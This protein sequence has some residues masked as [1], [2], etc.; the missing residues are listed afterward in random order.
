MSDLW[1]WLNY[2]HYCLYCQAKT[3]VQTSQNKTLNQS[4]LLT[5]IHKRYQISATCCIQQQQ[6]IVSAPIFFQL[7]T[8]ACWQ[9]P[10]HGMGSWDCK[11]ELG[12]KTCAMHII[13]CHNTANAAIYTIIYCTIVLFSLPW[14]SFIC[15][16]MNY[17]LI[18]ALIDSLTL[19]ML[20]KQGG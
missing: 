10:I 11:V 3:E 7:I 20:H 8:G 2:P 6:Y 19:G 14:Q 18:I 4:A 12:P 15:A 1:W 13:Y 5:F 9:L 17:Q 16:F